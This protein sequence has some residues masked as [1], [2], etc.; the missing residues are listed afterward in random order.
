VVK[1]VQERSEV[2]VALTDSYWVL[3]VQAVNAAQ[4][5]FVLVVGAVVSYSVVTPHTVRML[6]ALPP[7]R[8]NSFPSQ[9]WV[10]AAVGDAVG[11][12]VGAAVGV[13]V[14]AAV[15]VAV[16]AAVGAVVGAAVGAVGVAV[17]AAVGA[18]VGA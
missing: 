15:G 2:V 5:L 6:H 18:V 12:A 4:T 10:G 14:G 1:G 16:G 11:V 3:V 13:A 9:G 8:R 17:G 7:S